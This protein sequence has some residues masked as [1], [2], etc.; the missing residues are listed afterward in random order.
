MNLRLVA[1]IA[2]IG[3]FLEHREVCCQ[4]PP[5]GEIVAGE[6]VAGVKLG[7]SLSDSSVIR[8][9]PAI[10]DRVKSGQRAWPKT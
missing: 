7:S 2:S 4:T 5:R 10:R 1:I 8:L 9:N 6:R 3:F